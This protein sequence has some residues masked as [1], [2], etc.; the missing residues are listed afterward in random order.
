MSGMLCMS[1][2]QT[3]CFFSALLSSS[4]SFFFSSFVV[5]QLMP[6]RC[7]YV[8]LVLTWVRP[9][10]CSLQQLLLAY[11]DLTGPIPASFSNFS[12]NLQTLTLNSNN[13]SGPTTVLFNLC[14]GKT[15]YY[16]GESPRTLGCQEEEG[17]LQSWWASRKQTAGLSV[18]LTGMVFSQPWSFFRS[19]YAWI[20][21]AKRLNWSVHTLSALLG[22]SRTTSHYASLS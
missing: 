12:Q 21:S 22:C 13:L 20:H 5:N 7:D 19:L 11:N 16:A 10:V 17:Q 4:S 2:V 1:D 14:Q 18:T 8:G 15:C 3:R 9:P 6:R